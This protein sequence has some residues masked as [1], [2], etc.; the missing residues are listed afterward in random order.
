[1]NAVLLFPSHRYLRCVTLPLRVG[2][3]QKQQ[4]RSN[5]AEAERIQEGPVSAPRR[6]D[7]GSRR[8]PLFDRERPLAVAVFPAGR[9]PFPTLR[10]VRKQSRIHLSDTDL[11][12][13]KD[14][15]DAGRKSALRH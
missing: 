1:M 6:H 2:V 15:H 12:A 3:V 9:A 5:S 14:A 4:P 10:L 11:T 7:P 8:G 13:K